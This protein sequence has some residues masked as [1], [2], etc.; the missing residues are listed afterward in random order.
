MAP[1]RLPVS[2]TGNAETLGLIAQPELAANKRSL[3]R[4]PPIRKNKR[5]NVRHLSALMVFA[6][7]RS[8]V[9]TCVLAGGFSA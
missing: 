7:A 1:G 2:G 4:K 5:H 6:P 3:Q 9:P 8:V